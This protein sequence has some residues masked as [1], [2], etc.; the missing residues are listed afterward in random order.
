MRGVSIW[1]L[2]LGCAL[3]ANCLVADDEYSAKIRRTSHGIPHIVADDIGSLGFGQGYAFA[4]D[5][6]C[7]L[8]DQVIKVRSERSRWFGPGEEDENLNSDFGYLHLGIYEAA[9]ED[10]P[11]QPEEVRELVEGYAAGYNKWLDEVGADGLH[12]D[13]RGE[14]WVGPVSEIDLFAYYLD[15]GLLASGRQLMDFIATAQ[16]PGQA[17]L[18]GGDPEQLARLEKAE[19]GSN[20]WGIGKDLSETGGGMLL[21]N[22]H[23]PW[24][25][26]LRLWESHLTVPGELDVYGVGL[27]GVPGVLIGFNEAVAWTHTVSD[28]HRFTMYKLVLAPDDPTKYRYDGSTAQL[29]S[30][31]YE[32][33]VL[34][35]D[36]SLES[37]ERTLWRSHYGPVLNIT[38][39]GWSEDQVFTYRDANLG[40]RSLIA[41]FLAMTKAGSLEELQAA[42]E[43]HQGI[44]WVNTMATSREGK[45]WYI[46][47]T[48]APNLSQET[49]DAWLDDRE[50]GFFA[51]A[52]WTLGAVLLDGTSS[53]DEWIEE[54]GA[55]EPGLIPYSKLPQLER[56]D[57]I[58]NANDSHWLTN[59]AEPLE[60]YSLM[61]GEERSPRT[62]RTRMNARILTEGT[63]GH[64]GDDGKFSLAELQ[65]AAL[66]NRTM[67]GELLRDDV[68]ARCTGVDEYDG[69]DIAGACQALADW[70]LRYDLDSV[71]AIVWRELL[72]DFAFEV[73]LD[74]GVLL[75]EPFD[76]DDPVETPRGLVDAAAPDDDRILEALAAGVERLQEAG[77]SVDTPLGDAQFTRKGDTTIPMHGGGRNEGITNLII[78][79]V[80][81]S[82]L[83]DSMDRGDLI[84]A[85][86]DLTTDGYVVNYGTSFIMTVAYDEDG[87]RAEAFLTYSESS[88][89][90]SDH[91]ADQT[92]L[93]SD[94][95]WRACLFREDDILADPELETVSVSGPR[96]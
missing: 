47:S 19:L 68:V 91:Y 70:D 42:H 46:D 15:L 29:E 76:I 83:G 84:N 82:T 3:L 57:F 88:D 51:K 89:P 31:R 14:P 38:G 20:G 1:I 41:Q 4:Q 34:G 62:P 93:F 33:E 55:R 43:E 32:I 8:Q 10:Y 77:L 37:Q 65:Q 5:H 53:R 63:G 27:M 81:K 39:F 30:E 79:S 64:A 18:P 52:F 25:G 6:A 61:H 80:L 49:I 71:G 95:Q 60:G 28:G 56:D 66:S 7:V 23:F 35:E 94:K 2:P 87:P 59:P 78:Y 92:Q 40:N 11:D 54:D 85:D 12:G 96:D 48:P 67:M 24:E 90:E 45:A 21:A 72:G 73:F 58:F 75:A 50:N 69:V 9:R 17:Q 44:P 36:G 13:C 86:T 26:E 74:E 22:P 16:P